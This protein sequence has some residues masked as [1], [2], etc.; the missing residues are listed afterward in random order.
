MNLLIKTAQAI[1][2]P[3]KAEGYGLPLAE[4][5][6]LGTP[7]ICSDL[8]SS[9]EIGNG[10]PLYLT[11]SDGTAWEAAIA[12][13]ITCGRESMRQRNLLEF[14]RTFCWADHLNILEA[15]MSD[16]P[17]KRPLP[18]GTPVVYS[19]SFSELPQLRLEAQ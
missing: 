18:A 5:M 1:L 12:E 6:A 7:S 3:S 19:A 11:A 9:R 2:L 14:H 15:W 13:F 8:A 17:T 10:I 4:A 16:I